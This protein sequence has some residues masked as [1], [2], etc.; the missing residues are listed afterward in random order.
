MQQIWGPE[1]SAPT[2]ALAGGGA[3]AA[4]PQ[5]QPAEHRELLSQGSSAKSH[6]G[7]GWGTSDRCAQVWGLRVGVTEGPTRPHLRAPGRSCLQNV[8]PPRDG[9]GLAAGRC[10]KRSVQGPLPTSQEISWSRQ[11]DLVQ[12]DLNISAGAGPLGCGAGT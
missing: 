6:L 9:S 5:T 12:L 2:R 1:I 7:K 3:I 10:R 8:T 4:S 11:G